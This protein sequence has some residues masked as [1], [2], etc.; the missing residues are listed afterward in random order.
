MDERSDTLI[1]AYHTTLERVW[2][3][4]LQLHGCSGCAAQDLENK[5]KIS[6]AAAQPGR[7]GPCPGVCKDVRASTRPFYMVS[8]FGKRE[9]FASLSLDELLL[10]SNLICEAWQF[11]MRIMGCAACVE[12][13]MRYDI[14]TAAAEAHSLAFAHMPGALPDGCRRCCGPPVGLV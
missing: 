4:A 3:S 14:R 11:G 8:W 6:A 9:G 7:A 13:A 2:Q 5:L 12:A 1:V 10:V